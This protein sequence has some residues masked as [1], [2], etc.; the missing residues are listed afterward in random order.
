MDSYLL[1][2]ICVS[3]E[4]PYLIWKW[5]LDLP[6]IHVYCK[7]LWENK[8]NEDYERICNGLFAPI[9]QI[10]FGEQAPCLSLE[11]H[12]TVKIYEDW[13]M[14]SNKVYNRMLGG[15]KVPH[16]FSHFVLDTL[17]LQDISY[18]TNVHVVAS[19]LHKSKKGL[20]PPFP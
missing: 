17:L 15:T 8:Y 4:Y 16:W 1:D 2:V 11:G 14:T 9:Y 7:M 6:S 5:N 10:L 13:Y 3:G 19:S 18:Q 12:K 20:W